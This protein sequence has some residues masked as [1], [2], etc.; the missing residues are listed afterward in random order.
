VADLLF[1]TGNSYVDAVLSRLVNNLEGDFSAKLVGYYLTGSHVDGTAIA[2]S[3][4]DFVAVLRNA[5]D[6]P[7]IEQ[8]V[9]NTTPSWPVVERL[10]IPISE[11]NNPLYAEKIVIL[12]HGSRLLYGTD[13]RDQIVPQRGPYTKAVVSQCAKGIA[14]LRDLDSLP[15]TIDYP[16]PKGEFFGYEK[17]RLGG[18]DTVRRSRWYPVGTTEG[19]KEFASVVARCASALVAI[20]SGQLVASRAAV[21]DAYSR[22]VADD[23]TDFVRAVNVSCRETWGY[24]VPSASPDRRHLRELC[25]RMLH[26]ERHCLET[27]QD[28]RWL[29]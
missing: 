14:M 3:D 18:R 11:L 5:S 24:R 1:Q 26:F 20:K 15:P 17:T 10:L 8:Y 13:V 25:E 2:S 6:L 28:G 4:I 22:H 29:T 7:R 21:I 9:A 19:T 27:F 16:D 23:W 12:K